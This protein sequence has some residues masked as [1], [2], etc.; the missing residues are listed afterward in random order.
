MQISE[1]IKDAMRTKFPTADFTEYFGF[2]EQCKVPVECA[3]HSHHICPRAEFPELRKDKENLIDLGVADHFCAHYWLA[4]AVPECRNFQITVQY[5][6]DTNARSI[7]RD[8][9]PGFA[10]VYARGME[11]LKARNNEPKVKSAHVARL[12]KRWADPE[13]K[14][15]QSERSKKLWEDPEYRAEKTEQ[16]KEM[17]V[18]PEVKEARTTSLKKY[19][20]DL[21][22][23]A[24]FAERMKKLRADPEFK[25]AQSAR[26]KRQNAD[27]EFQR[28]AHDALNTPEHRAASGERRKIQNATPEFRAAQSERNHLRW[29]VKRNIINPECTLCNQGAI[30]CQSKFSSVDYPALG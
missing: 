18:R 24:A 15:A 21:E 5:M 12:R 14:V 16:L 17:L 3:M 1:R 8:E 23:R 27:P 28:K 9:L 30:T 25:A 2:L 11:A 10:E 29:H 20:E 4:L 7:S 13:Q 19:W 22:Q 6:A 26:A